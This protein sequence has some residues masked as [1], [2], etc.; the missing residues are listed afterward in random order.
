MNQRGRHSPISEVP[1]GG[2]P[3]F[4]SDRITSPP[5]YKK[6]ATITNPQRKLVVVLADYGVDSS[7]D[8]KWRPYNK[9]GSL[10]I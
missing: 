6:E 8:M 10:Y 9:N 2:W 7:R 4:T 1:Q 5:G 3:N